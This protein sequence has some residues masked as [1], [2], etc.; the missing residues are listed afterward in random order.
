MVR[1]GR[2]SGAVAAI[3]TV[4]AL[5]AAPG[6]LA[7]TPKQIYNDYAANGRL[8]RQYSKADLNRALHSA[9]LQ[10]YGK[11]SVMRKLKPAIRLQLAQP[12]TVT[13]HGGLP[14]TGLDIAY[15][16]GGGLLLVG[17]GFALRRLERGKS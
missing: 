1:R 15:L 12:S 6:A 14:F 16:V 3:A 17:T 11:P 9:A 5:A 7:A 2:V 4:A 10:G 8:D 13:R